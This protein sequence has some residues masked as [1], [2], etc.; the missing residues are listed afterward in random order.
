MA[1][2]WRTPQFLWNFSL[3]GNYINNNASFHCMGCINS[4]FLRKIICSSK[5][6]S[7]DALPCNLI[8]N[9]ICSLII[10]I[11]PVTGK[12]F[13]LSDLKKKINQ[14]NN[15]TAKSAKNMISKE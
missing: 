9:Y 13:G 8:I 4:L 2:L 10:L 3:Y 14:N 11:F 6:K 7:Y 15:A 12:T 1:F 5:V